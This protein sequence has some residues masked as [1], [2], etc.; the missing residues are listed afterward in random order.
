MPIEIAARQFKILCLPEVGMDTLLMVTDPS[1]P[2]IL[3]MTSKMDLSIYCS[4]LIALT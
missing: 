2:G 3:M 1:D 4:I